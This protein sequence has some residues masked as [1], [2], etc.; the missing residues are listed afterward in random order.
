[1]IWILN[2]F[3]QNL[4]DSIDN[5][6]LHEMFVKFG[7]VMS[8]KIVTSQDGKSKGYGFVQFGT[9]ESANAAID[10]VNGSMVGGKQM[11]VQLLEFFFF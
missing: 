9:E 6:K 2:I 3:M 4:S 5:V 8:C 7:N 1:M 11:Y 10:N